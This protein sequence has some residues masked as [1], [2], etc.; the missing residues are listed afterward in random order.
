MRERGS[1][2]GESSSALPSIW[3]NQPFGLQ[4]SMESLI[5]T[6]NFCELGATARTNQP[7]FIFWEEIVALVAHNLLTARHDG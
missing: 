4:A 7:V 3:S 1:G 6:Y 5:S 2:D